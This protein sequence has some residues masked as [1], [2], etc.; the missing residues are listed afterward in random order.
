M[1]NT[2]S[3]LAAQIP[4]TPIA[5]TTSISLTNV[6]INWTAPYNGGSPITA[7]SIK[8]KQANGTYS[9]TSSCNGALSSVLTS[10]SCTIPFTVL[11]ASP[12]NLPW[13]ASISANVVAIN[14]MG[15][16]LTS[17]EGN[18]AI[19]LSKPSAPI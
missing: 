5:P 8:I 12:Y 19:I 17:P 6:V 18:G 7:Y 4:S 3:V 2:I 16:S 15:S 11:Q 13:G 1:S 14:I 10:P 9:N